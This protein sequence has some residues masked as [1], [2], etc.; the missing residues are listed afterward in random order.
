MAQVRERS[1]WV[2]EEAWGRVNAWNSVKTPKSRTPILKLGAHKPCL[3][4]HSLWWAMC[5][6][7]MQP[8]WP[9]K[10][11]VT[12][13]C[14][15][16]SINSYLMWCRKFLE[17]LVLS[18]TNLFHPWPGMKVTKCLRPWCIDGDFHM[19]YSQNLK[20]L[21]IWVVATPYSHTSIV[22]ASCSSFATP[23]KIME[24]WEQQL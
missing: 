19:R 18:M 13:P 9:W 1:C 20:N 15:F 5:I 4:L 14:C 10:A 24:L 3:C 22:C 8:H 21:L 2:H 6:S 16:G 7:P 12:Q 17:S 23:N 11:Y